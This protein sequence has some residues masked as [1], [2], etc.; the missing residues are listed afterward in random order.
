VQVL[1]S[2]VHVLLFPREFSLFYDF[3]KC[4]L[5]SDATQRVLHVEKGETR[6][7]E[8]LMFCWTFSFLTALTQMNPI[9]RSFPTPNI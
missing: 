3:P 4:C 5:F 8:I 9:M 2:V 7:D 1:E 6:V